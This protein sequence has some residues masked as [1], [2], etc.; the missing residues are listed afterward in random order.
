M[1]IAIPSHRCVV[2]IFPIMM[3]HEW[4]HNGFTTYEHAA[5]PRDQILHRV[6]SWQRG[7][8]CPK[9]VSLQQ[10]NKAIESGNCYQCGTKLIEY[11]EWVDEFTPCAKDEGY[12]VYQLH[13]TFCW[14][15]D[16]SQDKEIYRK[17]PVDAQSVCND[18]VSV[19]S[20][21]LLGADK[22]L[23]PGILAIA[24]EEPTPEEL[25]QVRAM[26]T[27][28]FQY[29]HDDAVAKWADGKT[30]EITSLHRAAC[31][32]L[33]R[34]DHEF[35]KKAEQRSMKECPA[36]SES[37]PY[38]AN[39]CRSCSTDL[40]IFYESRGIL[41]DEKEDPFVRKL[42]ERKKQAAANRA[43]ETAVPEKVKPILKNHEPVVHA[44][45]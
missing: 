25:A 7:L 13:D 38:N 44:G 37:M 45:V 43:A 8:Y 17:D 21:G 6:F 1:S 35:M 2:S 18:F 32:W 16:W 39:R 31:K 22:G 20:G 23:R 4:R 33:G 9:H 28:F 14:G 26:Q 15:R 12:A 24:G 36:C 40:D 19:Y 30:V 42:I 41:P 11:P 3:R 10:S 5:A 27:A 29:L 34:M